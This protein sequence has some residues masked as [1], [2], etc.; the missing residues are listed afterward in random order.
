[1]I[2]TP[3][4]TVLDNYCITLLKLSNT[5][6][7]NYKKVIRD[8]VAEFDNYSVKDREFLDLAGE[9]L[10][11]IH[12]NIWNTEGAIRRAEEENLG[13]EEVGRR[14]LKVRDLNR[15]R[16]GVRKLVIEY[17]GEGVP[18]VKCNYAGGTK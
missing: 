17:F 9:E 5:G 1:M 13:L 8:C 6:D 11:E 12:K 2:K 16:Q 7:Q 18:D 15:E 3:I 14:A 10:L 4:D